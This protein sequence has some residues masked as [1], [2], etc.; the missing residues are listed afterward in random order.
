MIGL[1]NILYAAMLTEYIRL[2]ATDIMALA[3]MKNIA[4]CDTWCELKNPINHRVFE[5]MLRPRPLGWGHICLGITPK[6][7]PM[8]SLC[9]IWCLAF[10]CTY[11]GVVG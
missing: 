5:C 2:S 9:G 8:Q 1:P 11:K 4:E 6:D 7:T 10:Q 3:L